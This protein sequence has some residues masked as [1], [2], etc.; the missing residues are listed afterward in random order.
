MIRII[1]GPEPQ[2]IIDAREEHL[3]HAMLEAGDDGLEELEGYE[4]ARPQLHTR[5]FAK[6]AYCESWTQQESQ[7]VEHFRPRRRPSRIDW[8]ALKRTAPSPLSRRDEDRFARGLPPVELERVRWPD[9]NR[10]A[11]PERGYWWLAWTWENLVFGCVSCNGRKG[12]RFPL[13]QGSPAL[14]LHQAPPG[15]ERPLLLDPVDPEV[16]PMDV[17]QFRWDGKHWR[18]FPVNDHAR[19]A[20]T[21]AVLGLDGTSLLTLYSAKV[22][23]LDQMARSLRQALDGNAPDGM[24]RS[25]W[26]ELN[27]CALA[28]ERSFLALTHD[29]LAAT[30]AAEIER[31]GLSLRRPVLRHIDANEDAAPRPPLPPRA[32]LGGLPERLQYRIRWLRHFQGPKDDLRALLVDLCAERPSTTDELVELLGRASALPGHLREL[33]GH[34]LVRD[35]LTGRWGPAP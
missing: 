35:A 3:S 14:G 13:A 32:G 17:I 4:V 10:Q 1:R 12:T 5:Q 6:C 31:Y 30:F 21:I 20:W 33:E 24:V 15:A 19:A 22:R 34:A 23:E 25:E 27:Q 11:Q 2:E 18:P 7:P 16:D 8:S 26:I 9:P 29:W 28:P